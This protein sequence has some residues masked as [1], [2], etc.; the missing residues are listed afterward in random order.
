MGQNTSPPQHLRR[1][2]CICPPQGGAVLQPPC[3]LA[4]TWQCYVI[5]TQRVS[6]PTGISFFPGV[7]L[8]A[9]HQSDGEGYAL[10]YGI[11]TFPMSDGQ[12]FDLSHGPQ[13]V[14]DVLNGNNT[15][16]PSSAGIAH[17]IGW[18]NWP[19]LRNHPSRTHRQ[20]GIELLSGMQTAFGLT[21]FPVELW[22]G[23][24]EWLMNQF[25]RPIF[26]QGRFPALSVRTG[27]DLD[28][29]NNSKYYTHILVPVTEAQ[30][31]DSARSWANRRQLVDNALRDGRT[32][33]SL[34]GSWGRVTINGLLPGNIQLDLAINSVLNMNLRIIPS[35]NGFAQI[36]LFRR[37]M[38]EVVYEEPVFWATAGTEITRTFS[39]TFPGGDQ[40]YWLTVEI[41][42]AM[43]N[44]ADVIYTTPIFLS[45]NP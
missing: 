20:R 7:E 1:A 28:L 27:R 31:N 35:V 45:S 37:D 19:W 26:T 15:L 5:N 12:V 18:Y 4:N 32:I 13:A 42:D 3:A 29:L 23:E 8:S 40:N 36:R 41:T 21:S 22:R 14:I 39:R 38:A 25:T 43:G 34:N 17:P 16:Q 24:T 33:V 30:W 6:V 11:T 44:W 2:V 9:A 10:G